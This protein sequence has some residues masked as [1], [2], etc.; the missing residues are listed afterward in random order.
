MFLVNFFQ[1]AA[2]F[3]NLLDF[4]GVSLERK[5]SSSLQST[6]S[7]DSDPLYVSEY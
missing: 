4:L 3:D 7:A 2:K 1:R 5:L 6:G